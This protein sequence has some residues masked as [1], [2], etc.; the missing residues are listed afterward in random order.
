MGPLVCAVS[1]QA[2][3]HKRAPCLPD[4]TR[5]KVLN[6]CSLVEHVILATAGI[7][8]I[9]RALKPVAY[10]VGSDWVGRLPDEERITC[11]IEGAQI[12]FVD[13]REQSSTALLADYERRRNAEK[14]AAFESF[15]QGQKPAEKPW[16]PVTDYSFEARK[17]IEGP[18]AQLIKD[19]FQPHRV[20]DAGCGP[21]HL[22]RLLQ[23]LNVDAGGFD[24]RRYREW[25]V[26]DGHLWPFFVSDITEYDDRGHLYDCDLIICREVLE[27]LTVA[28]LATAV[29][30]LV[31]LSNKYLYITTRFTGGS[32][33]LDVDGS[34][35]L[36]PT[37]IS[38]MS[39]DYVR[40]LLVLEGCKRR[41]DLEQ[42]LDWQ[43]KRRVLIYEV[44]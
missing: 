35:N 12:V 6:A 41:V 10:V 13:C 33:L 11:E 16:E 40:S 30:N 28:Q 31:Q 3:M 32:H 36:D 34:D 17:A 15:V 43:N 2:A 26:P 22:V 37:H 39:Q 38:M 5:L 24:T 44:A 8:A 21:G 23:E 27:H 29:R 25:V 19:T 20:A 7:P 18:H 9:I 1:P 42:R 14:L 4:L